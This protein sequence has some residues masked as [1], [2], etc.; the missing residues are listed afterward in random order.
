MRQVLLRD[1]RLAWVN[2][3]GQVVRISSGMG[4]AE[5]GF[6]ET[7][8]SNLPPSNVYHPDARTRDLMSRLPDADVVGL[9]GPGVTPG[10]EQ[11]P[12]GQRVHRAESGLAPPGATF[13]PLAG[14]Q[15]N[16]RGN[17]Q[18]VTLATNLGGPEQTIASI[19]E[20]PKTGGQDAEVIQVQLG[21]EL[22]P[23]MSDLASPYTGTF[24]EV[25]AIVE[26][27]VGNAFFT[28]EVD[29]N[30]GTSF[31]IAASWIR[32]S[33]KVGPVATL[34][35]PDINI[36]LRASLGYGNAVSVGISSPTRRTLLM[37]PPPPA[38]GFL[39]AGATS[40]VFPIP[41]WA[42]GFTLVDAGGLGVGTA[43]P[44]YAINLS[45]NGGSPSVLYRLASRTNVGNQVEG[46]FPIPAKSR[47]IFIKNQLAVSAKSPKVIFNL[48]F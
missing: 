34:L 47:F 19:V 2:D 42:I 43:D 32:I 36:V 4:G 46:Q 21:M 23:E 8:Q 22:P 16:N 29:W 26:W 14:A 5:P 15:V 7:P 38:A 3:D 20:T 6:G 28:A 10:G 31:A 9:R 24:L 27:G 48:A 45:E 30:Q 35:L 39:G 11:H 33:A 17:V 1:G 41:L 40:A 18:T 25:T 13:R 37:V 44:D 12:G